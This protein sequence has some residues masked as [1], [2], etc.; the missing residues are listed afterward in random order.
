MSG[1]CDRCGNNPCVCKIED[2][3]SVPFSRFYSWFD[4][5][6]NSD[7]AQE[8]AFS[9][10]NRSARDEQ[11]GE[12]SAEAAWDFQDNRIK[13]LTSIIED[14]QKCKTGTEIEILNK[15]YLGSDDKPVL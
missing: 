11:I 14:Y 5:F 6:Y 7:I 9:N 4:S 13:S 12:F 15:K 2:M 1:S 10:H 3:L 8:F